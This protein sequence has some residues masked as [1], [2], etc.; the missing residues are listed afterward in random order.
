M[1]NWSAPKADTL[2]LMPPVPSATMY[3]EVKRAAFW[4]RVGYRS[5]GGVSAGTRAVVARSS[6]PCEYEESGHGGCRSF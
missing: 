5:G 3:R 4:S 6:M 1:S 2:G